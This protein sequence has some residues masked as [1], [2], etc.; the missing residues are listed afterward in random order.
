[1]PSYL[2]VG[3]RKYILLTRLRH[4]CSSLHA[5]L[6]RVNIIQSPAC[7]C[8]NNIENAKHYMFECNLYNEQRNALFLSLITVPNISLDLLI[9]GSSDF[10]VETNTTIILAVSKFIKVVIITNLGQRQKSA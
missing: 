4:S 8:G 2:V 6:F 3:E 7:D 5:D 9:N 10:P 1:M